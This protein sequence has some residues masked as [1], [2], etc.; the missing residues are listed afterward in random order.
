MGF[1]LLDSDLIDNFGYNKSILVNHIYFWCSVH[2]DKG[3]KRA[4][5]DGHIWMFNST[6]DII[7]RFP[8]M[9]NSTVSRHLRELEEDGWIVSG[10]YNRLKIDKTKWY[11]V[12]EKYTDFLSNCSE[13]FIEIMDKKIQEEES[14]EYSSSGEHNETNAN[15]NNVT[16]CESPIAHFGPPI[17]KSIYPSSYNLIYC[18]TCFYNTS[19]KEKLNKKKSKTNANQ[20]LFDE[21]GKLKSIKDSEK[22]SKSEKFK[23]IHREESKTYF[24]K[25]RKL[26]KGSVPGKEVAFK[27][28]VDKYKKKDWNS[29]NMIQDLHDMVNWIKRENFIRKKITEHDPDYWFGSWKNYRTFINQRAWEETNP[30]DIEKV[31]EIL[32]LEKKE[33]KQKA[34]ARR[35]DAEYDLAV[36]NSRQYGYTPPINKPTK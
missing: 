19:N 4:V 3:V 33:A 22:L 18:Q 11:R 16:D 27:Y 32:I 10:C 15:Q 13:E 8:F 14:L 23:Y 30:T 36:E 26:Y 1:I 28:F 29:Y 31:K 35:A 6:S 17:Q 5:V 25:A 21:T 7:S 9:K 12:T 2:K 24:E 34:E 20:D